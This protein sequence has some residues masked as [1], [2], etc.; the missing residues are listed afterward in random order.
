MKSFRERQAARRAKRQ[1][2]LKKSQQP[3]QRAAGVFFDQC[4]RRGLRH[5]MTAKD[6]AL[7]K[8]LIELYSVEEVEQLIV[9]AFEYE[10][11][12]FPFK[13]YDIAGIWNHHQ[14]IHQRAQRRADIQAVHKRIEEQEAD[15]LLQPHLTPPAEPD[16]KPK[17][18]LTQM[19][20]S[21]RKE[22]HG[23]RQEQED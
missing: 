13:K 1:G 6:F 2:Q 23:R 22:Q 4:R 5:L 18:D 17:I 9:T 16:G 14:E 3:H 8:R 11:L 21:V 7:L 20:K 15:E 10:S 12:C 19:V